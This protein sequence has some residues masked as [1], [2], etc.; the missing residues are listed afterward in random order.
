MSKTSA[1]IIENHHRY[2]SRLMAAKMA[3]SSDDLNLDLNPWGSPTDELFRTQGHV[4]ARYPS[5]AVT[6]LYL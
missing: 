1:K 5:R 3:A 2:P 6:D 4:Y